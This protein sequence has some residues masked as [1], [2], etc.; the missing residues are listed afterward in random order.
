MNIISTFS[1]CGA[2]DLG[3]KKAGFR[4]ILATDV[5]DT[6]CL[7]LSKNKLADKI[8]CDD[9]KNISFNPYKGKIDG[10]IGGP[11]CQPYSQTRHYLINKKKGF[12]DEISGY[13]VPQF[14]RVVS[15]VDPKFFVFENVDGFAYKTHKDELDYFLNTSDELGYKNFYKV[16]NTAN[17]G[18]PQTRKRFLCVGIRKDLPDFSFPTE[19]H[20]NDI[21]LHPDLQPWNT[22]KD[23]LSDFDNVLESEKKNIPG[24]K[25]RELFKLIPPG[26]NYLF[27]T[28]KRGCKKPQFKW[29]SRYWTFL[30]KL[31]PDRPSWTIQASTSENQGPFH[32]RNRFLR[33]DEI[34]RIQTIDDSFKLEGEFK[35]KWKQVGNAFPSMMA[36][37]VANEIR[38]VLE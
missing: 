33:I 29:K 17:Y 22:C 32:W 5:W 8:I 36:M 2:M 26:D 7:S 28:A 18:I 11:P 9:I 12:N 13:T 30:L 21:K 4:T 24:G 20:T 14:L 16:I 6:A 19:T 37:I 10:V 1:G 38:K 15:E 3:F 35:D 23:C 27:F 34:K 31:S 25:H